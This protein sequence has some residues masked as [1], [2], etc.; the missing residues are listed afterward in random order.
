MHQR[1]DTVERG[2]FAAHAEDAVGHDD[3]TAACLRR[4]P[5][6]SLELAHV[7]MFVDVLLGWPSKRDS[8]DDAAVIEFIANHR[9]LIG[10]ERRDEAH[11]RGIGRRIQHG[12]RAAVEGSETPLQCDVWERGS[13]DE[14]NRAGASAIGGDRPL[15]GLDDLGAQR[16][17]EIAVGIHA[18]ECGAS[19]TLNEIARAVNVTPRHDAADYAFPALETS[20]LLH[21]V[22]PSGQNTNQSMGRHSCLAFYAPIF[23]ATAINLLLMG[24]QRSLLGMLQ[25][26]KGAAIVLSALGQK[27]TYAVQPMSALPESRHLHPNSSG[28]SEVQFVASLR[29]ESHCFG[30]PA[31]ADETECVDASNEEGQRTRKLRGGKEQ[32]RSGYG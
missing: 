2:M 32:S 31:P 3:R 29:S 19:F 25:Q 6:R 26:L 17:A 15:L 7:E 18:Q 12:V 28:L 14:A 22:K 4:E 9:R 21:F 1:H 16:H 8:I 27:Q 11:H 5:K 20:A 30:L 10:H 23:R 13:A 24:G